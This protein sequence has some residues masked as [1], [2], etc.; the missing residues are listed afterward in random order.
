VEE[1]VLAT[2]EEWKVPS[3]ALRDIV[4]REWSRTW[5]VPDDI[6]AESARRLT[7]WA[8]AEY[9]SRLDIPQRSEQAFKVARAL[10]PV[11][12]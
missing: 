1:H 2:W 7:A 12:L 9:G 10:V 6:F 8:Q 4:E 5:R 3:E 11:H